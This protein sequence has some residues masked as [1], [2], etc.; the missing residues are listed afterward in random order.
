MKT[1]NIQ[2]SHSKKNQE[3]LRLIE[4]KESTDANSKM[5]EMSEISEGFHGSQEKK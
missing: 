3:D 5:K 1:E 4:E 2:N